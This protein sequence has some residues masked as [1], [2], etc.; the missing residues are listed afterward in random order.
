GSSSAS[1]ASSHG[2]ALLM[3]LHLTG[4]DAAVFLGVEPRF[5]LID[6]VENTRRLDRM[7]FRSLVSRAL[8]NLDLLASPDRAG[9]TRIESERIR[10]VIDFV[11]AEYAYTVLDLSHSD[12]AALDSL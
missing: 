9:L 6:A 5:S 12:P 7:F 3:D 4:G 8:P 11:A 2:R 1:S 10:P